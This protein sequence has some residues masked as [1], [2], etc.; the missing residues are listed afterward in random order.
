MA[1]AAVASLASSA[2]FA[3]PQIPSP[4]AASETQLV[5]APTAR[6]PRILTIASSCQP[7]Y[8]AAAMRA[9]ATGTTAVRL[10][11]TAA[12]K[13]LQADVTHSSG[14]T[15][16]HRLL[17]RAALQAFATCPFVP[18]V[19]SAGRPVGGTV[20]LTFDWHF[21]PASPASAPYPTT[22]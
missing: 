16:E 12:G 10:S 17:D 8:P 18:G 6:P 15:R 20:D 22:P 11:V 2:G 5:V 1:V 14:P 13:I 7:V 19:D 9:G 21:E 3:Q 4:Q